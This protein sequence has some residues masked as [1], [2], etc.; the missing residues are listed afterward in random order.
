[1][2]SSRSGNISSLVCVYRT[3]Y[4]S[5][6]SQVISSRVVATESGILTETLGHF[7]PCLWFKRRIFFMV[8]PDSSKTGILSQT[9]FLWQERNRISNTKK[10]KV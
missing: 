8:S 3:R 10:Q 9:R 4:S 2:F 5:A 7:E 1:M 6:G